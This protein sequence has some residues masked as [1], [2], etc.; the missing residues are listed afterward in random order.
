[1]CDQ[2]SR[3]IR[4]S[5]IQQEAASKAIN[6]TLRMV[7]QELGVRAPMIGTPSENREALL[8]IIRRLSLGP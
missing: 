1:M 4:E 7:A 5:Q 6:R 2:R 3:R 8:G